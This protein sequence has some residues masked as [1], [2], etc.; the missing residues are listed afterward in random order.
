MQQEGVSLRVPALTFRF[1]RTMN[2][3]KNK[4]TNLQGLSPDEKLH[5]TS[6]SH[7][8]QENSNKRR[9]SVQWLFYIWTFYFILFLFLAQK[10]AMVED[11]GKR[12]FHVKEARSV[13][14]HAH[15]HTEGKSKTGAVYIKLWGTNSHFLPTSC[16][17][18][19]KY[20]GKRFLLKCVCA[21]LFFFFFLFKEKT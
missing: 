21:F 12:V 13:C 2:L 17:C 5:L 8:A 20:T 3:S 19:K 9:D 11:R 16:K 4:Q 7:R 18:I 1:L 6:S 10:H 14:V 15:A